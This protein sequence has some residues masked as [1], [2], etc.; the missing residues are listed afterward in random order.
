MLQLK[1]CL[2]EYILSFDHDGFVVNSGIH[3]LTLNELTLYFKTMTIHSIYTVKPALK[4]T[5]L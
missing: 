4:T 1:Q 5:S 3:V 2:T